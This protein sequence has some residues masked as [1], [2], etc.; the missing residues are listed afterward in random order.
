MRCLAIDSSTKSLSIAITENGKLLCERNQNLGFTH[1]ETL[2]PQMLALLED[3]G[4]SFEDM[5]F[6]AVTSGPGSYTGIRIGLSTMK[7]I[8]WYL[9]KPLFAFSGLKVMSRAFANTNQFILPSLDARSKRVFSAL[10]KGEKTILPEAN[11]TSNILLEELKDIFYAGRREKPELYLLGDGSPVIF[12]DYK[13]DPLSQEHV[14]LVQM[15]DGLAGLRAYHLARL[16]EEAYQ[17]GLRPGWQEAEANYCSPTQA[18]RVR[19]EKLSHMLIRKASLQD[20]DLI[21]YIERMTFPTPW[22]KRSLQAQLD[23]ENKHAYLYLIFSDESEEEVLGYAGYYMHLDE[24]EILNIAVL[25]EARRA[26]VGR[27]LLRYL[28]QEA[29]KCGALRITL[30]VRESNLPAQKLYY[31]LGFQKC[32]IRKGYYDKPREDALILELVLTA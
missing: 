17:K 10:F 28:L 30:E 2:L 12:R 4:L 9:N 6:F 31:S 19:Q 25:E 13:E 3:A 21:H 26:G 16:A 22:S 14:T 7:S 11:R 32:G 20:L 1:S 8:A 5:D 29:R 23:P 15:E 27:K 18:E 24:A